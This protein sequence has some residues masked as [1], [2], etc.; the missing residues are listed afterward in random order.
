M[1]TKQIKERTA[2]K[3]KNRLFKPILIIIIIILV[4]FGG[5]FSLNQLGYI[6][7]M[8]LALD[9]QKKTALSKEDQKLLNQVK[10]CI[11]LPE[12]INPTMAEIT[13]V[14][15]LRKSQPTFF[16]TAENGQHLIIYSDQ[17]IIF[18]T[19]INKIVKVGPVQF[20]NT[21]EAVAPV[22]FAIYNSTSDES[23]TAAMEEK[24]TSTF[25]NAVVTIKEEA[26]GE[27]YEKTMVIDLVGNNPE[28]NKIAEAVGGIVAQ[29]PSDEEKPKGVAVLIIIGND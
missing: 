18:D 12:D 23:K 19:K 20:N 8:K 2:L 9:I 22:L 4:L 13:D 25:N 7:A 6:K 24:L 27:N 16:A 5:Y 21:Q 3:K 10:Q 29:L 15:A 11:M 26:K 28:M 17:A 1:E 14:E